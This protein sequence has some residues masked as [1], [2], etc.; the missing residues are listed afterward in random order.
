MTSYATTAARRPARPRT[1]AAAVRALIFAVALGAAGRPAAAQQPADAP[2]PADPADVASIDAIIAALYDVISGPAGQARD[3]DRFRSLFVPGA[4][5]IPVAVPRDGGPARTRMAS[6]ERYIARSGPIM[7]ERGFFEREISRKVERFGHIAH[8]FST[9]ASYWKE[10]DAE[11]FARGINSIQ[12]MHDGDRWW[13][14]TIF[15]DSE[16]P[17]QPI[18]AEYLSGN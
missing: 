10:D 8:V 15:W 2:P 12:L 18:P 13:V 1:A 11:P 14:V 7:L 16:R 6:V 5:L 3:W 9:Y 4:R 17:G